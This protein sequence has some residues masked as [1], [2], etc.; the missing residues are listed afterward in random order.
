MF[1][2]HV[3]SLLFLALT[4]LQF[5]NRG[6]KFNS[7]GTPTRRPIESNHQGHFS[8]LAKTTTLFYSITHPLAQLFSKLPTD[9]L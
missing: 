2:Q 4:T 6:F 7:Q 9:F 5:S 8:Y 1:M 3:V